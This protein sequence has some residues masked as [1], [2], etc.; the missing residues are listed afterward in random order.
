MFDIVRESPTGDR[1]GW[2]GGGGYVC[3]VCGVCGVWCVCVGG[4]GGGVGVGGGTGGG[5]DAG[6]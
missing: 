1:V 5:K 3:G 6:H 2:W 4:V